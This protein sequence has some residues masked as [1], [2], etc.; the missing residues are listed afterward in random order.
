MSTLLSTQFLVDRLSSTQG[1]DDF[2]LWITDSANKEGGGQF[3]W[4]QMQLG[5]KRM[6]K[7]VSEVAQSQTGSCQTK[8]EG[9]A[10]GTIREEG[11]VEDGELVEDDEEGAE[12]D[13]GMNTAKSNLP[14]SV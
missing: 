2:N 6:C 13:L 11:E 1:Q 9:G 14:D 12:E 7:V 5:V 3:N 8:P 10:D 4:T